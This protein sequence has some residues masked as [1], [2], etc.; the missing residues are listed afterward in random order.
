M[1]MLEDNHLVYET[2]LL[3]LIVACCMLHL[4]DALYIFST[5]T[6]HVYIIHIIETYFFVASKRKNKK[7]SN[8]SNCRQ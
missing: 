7:T 6:L 2:P 4:Q 8:K 5:T 1:K 3:L